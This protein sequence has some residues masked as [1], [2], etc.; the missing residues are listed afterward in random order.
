MDRDQYC[1]DIETYLCQKNDGHLIRIVG[2]A[3][4]LVSGWAARG[5]PAKVVQHGVDRYLERYYAKGPRRRPV[6]ID[7]CEADVLD[8]FDDWRRSVGVLLAGSAKKPRHS[9]VAHIDGVIGRL[10]ARQTNPATPDLDAQISQTIERLESLRAP[11]AT[12]R[13]A[14]RAQLVDQLVEIDRALAAASRNSCSS[15]VRTAM[16]R[17]AARD[18]E[19]FRERMEA[20]VYQQAID[21]AT[22]R[23]LREALGLPTIAYG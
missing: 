21:T 6:R 17:E 23:A 19:P 4:E 1:R 11:A 9:L 10:V 3:F 22:D 16:V 8:A 12:A 2:P 14:T 18:L 13:G 15:E 7:F 20:E 5:I